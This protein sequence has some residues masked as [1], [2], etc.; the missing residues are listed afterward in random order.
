MSLW[1]SLVFEQS[2][3]GV[4]GD[5]ASAAELLALI[6]SLSD[7]P[8]DQS[9]AITGSVNQFGDIQAIGGVNE[10]IEGFFDICAARG[11]T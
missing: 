11:L 9:L 7:I 5:S 8:I 3:G 10:K 6:S 4:D 1:A 2:Y